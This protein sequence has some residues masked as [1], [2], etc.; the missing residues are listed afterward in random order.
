MTTGPGPYVEAF[1]YSFSPLDPHAAHVDPP[2]VAVYETLLTRGADGSPRAGMAQSWTVDPSGL[3][4][5]LRLRDDLRFHSGAA[6]TAE[7]VVSSL[8][9]LRWEMHV[10][11]GG[12]QL[13]YWDPVERVVATDSNTLRFHLHHPHPRLFSLLWGTH[14]AIHCEATRRTRGDAFGVEVADGTGP[15]RLRSWSPSEVVADRVDWYPGSS[16]RVAEARWHALPQSHDR[17]SALING[18]ALCAHALDTAAVQQLKD[19]PRFDMAVQPQPSSLYLTLDWRRS[20]LGF[21]DVRTRRAIG[22]AIDRR[23]IVTDAFDGLATPSWGP[24]P[25]G[26]DFYEPTADLAGVCDRAAA[27]HTLTSLG[28]H[29]GVDGV[30]ER[31]GTRL[32]VECVVQDDESFRAVFACVEADLRSIG[33]ELLPRFATPFADFYS[34]VQHGTGAALSKWLWPDPMDALIGFSSSGTAPFPNWEYA[35]VPALDQAFDRFLR[36]CSDDDLTAAALDVQQVFAAELPYLPL[37]TPHDVWAW[38]RRVSG[39][40]PVHGDLYPRYDDV[41]VT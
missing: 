41:S 39:F 21:D 3:I 37:V 15:F 29:R 40:R 23:Q 19:D 38:S 20:D 24:L 4:W 25:A 11:P 27:A 28:W 1:E 31:T 26:H 10:L 33:I 9:A 8:D 18:E 6:C 2:A 13:W 32:S 30:L 12:R 7:A 16:A 22:L 35:S 36:G 17:I 5:E 34:A 14:T